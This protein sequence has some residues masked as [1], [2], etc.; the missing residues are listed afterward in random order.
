MM[1][2]SR[3]RDCARSCTGTLCE[4][5]SQN[6][7]GYKGIVS[8]CFVKIAA[9]EQKHSLRV[10]RLEGEILLH[11]RGLGRFLF[12]H[13]NLL[14]HAYAHPRAYPANLSK[15]DDMRKFNLDCR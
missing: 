5:D 15:S 9:P 8:V 4:D 10:F 2:E 6:L 3:H 14:L 12:C 13:F 1:R 11:H 7:A